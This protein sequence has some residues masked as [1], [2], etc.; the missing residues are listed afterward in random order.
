M[1]NLIS[2]VS[3]C[4]IWG[5]K[6]PNFTFFKFVNMPWLRPALQ[7]CRDKVERGC[8][9]MNIPLSNDTKIVSAFMAK[10]RSQTLSYKNVMELPK[11]IE[12]FAPPSGELSPTPTK[13]GLVI[14]V[15]V[16]RSHLQNMFAS[17]A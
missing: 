3:I 8:I 7:S 13:L 14:E 6:I 12:L 16:H 9:S 11:H 10:L 1:P 2:I 5:Q 15:S 4:R 17:D